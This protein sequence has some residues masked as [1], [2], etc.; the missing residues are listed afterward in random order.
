MH[1]RQIVQSIAAGEGMQTG[2]RKA[3]DS[4][5]S[6]PGPRTATIYNAPA[7]AQRWDSEDEDS[8]R[9]GNAHCAL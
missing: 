2:S 6:E 7:A 4:T 8:G 5:G 1:G 9:A 3:G